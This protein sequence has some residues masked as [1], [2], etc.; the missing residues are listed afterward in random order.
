M[1]TSRDKL[2]VSV[3][4]HNS[5]TR[6]EWRIPVT[7]HIVQ[8]FGSLEQDSFSFGAIHTTATLGEEGI[9]KLQSA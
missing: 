6:I 4:A 8:P 3:Y 2:S 1:V 7:C 5:P 9:G